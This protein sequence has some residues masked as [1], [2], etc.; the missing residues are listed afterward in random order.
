VTVPEVVPTRLK[1]P[2]AVPPRPEEIPAVQAKAPVELVTVQ[3]VADKP[4]ASKIL[5]VETEPILMA[6]LVP[7]SRLIAVAVVDTEM[8]GAVEVKVNAVALVPMVSIEA[9]PVKAPPVLTLSP[10]LLV[11]VNVPVELPMATA[12]LLV[13]VPI[14]VA[15]DPEVFR[16]K[17]APVKVKALAPVL[18]EEVERPERVRVP[19]VAVKLSAPVL[20]AKPFEAVIV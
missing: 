17:G 11:R 6:P 10:P 15:P 14:L 13:E 9:T 20:K 7:A 4:P 2:V 3:P 5:P 16:F 19:L 1:E 18:M 12:P 8:V